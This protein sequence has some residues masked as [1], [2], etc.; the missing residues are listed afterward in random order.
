MQRST[1][2]CTKAI[3]NPWPI[4]V[5]FRYLIATYRAESEKATAVQGSNDL[6][7]AETM[8]VEVGKGSR[9]TQVGVYD[10]HE[11]RWVS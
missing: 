11:R 9:G 10:R 2:K 4:G 6:Q 8:S 5:K 1:Q 3:G 7:E